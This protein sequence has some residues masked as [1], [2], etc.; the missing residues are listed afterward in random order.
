MFLT[1]DVVH[2]ISYSI[3]LLNTD[4]HIVDISSSQ[5]MTRQQFVR[6]T[7]ETIRCQIPVLKRGSTVPVSRPSIQKRK[8]TTFPSSSSPNLANPNLT[9][10]GSLLKVTQGIS[11]SKNP[12][13]QTLDHEAGRPSRESG[14]TAPM[15]KLSWSLFDDKAG[16]FGGMAGLGSQSAWE[17]QMECVLKVLLLSITLM[18]RKSITLSK[19]LHYNKLNRH[20]RMIQAQ[21]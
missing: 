13:A 16:P 10:S 1:A 8:L 19:L 15:E 11:M 21:V 20:L 3:F 14:R 17:A 6:N 12:S 7:M 4:L 9:R 2:A 5:R 18:S